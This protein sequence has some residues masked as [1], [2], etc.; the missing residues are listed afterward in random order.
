MESVDWNSCIICGDGSKAGMQCPLNNKHLTKD[1]DKIKSYENFL[2]SL[3]KLKDNGVPAEVKVSIDVSA[4]L[5]LEKRAS[6][7]KVCINRF[8]DEKVEKKIQ[9]F[10]RKSGD[11]SK[12]EE[13]DS[14]A[15]AKIPRVKTDFLL[16]ILCQ[17]DNIPHNH[18]HLVQ[19]LTFSQNVQTMAQA[20]GDSALLNRV[21]GSDLIAIDA[22]YHLACYRK[23]Q[24][25]YIK[26]QNSKKSSSESTKVFSEQAFQEVVQWIKDRYADGETN[27]LLKDLWDFWLERREEYGLDAMQNRTIF[28]ERLLAEFSGEMSEHNYEGRKVALCFNEGLKEV[29]NAVIKERNFSEDMKVLMKASKII[30]N[31][32][33]N[34]KTFSFLG[35][36]DS[37]C[38]R[39]SI[40]ASLYS[41]ISL[42]IN[43]IDKNVE[44]NHQATLSISQLVL[45]NL[46][47]SKNKDA[48]ISRHI[49]EAPLSVY[50]G[51]K[52]HVLTRSS[53]LIDI[54]YNLGL[55][56]H[57]KQVVKLEKQFASS[58]CHQ[59]TQQNAVIPPQL[60]KN[61]FTVGAFDNIDYNTSSYT[62][63]DS[64]HGTGISLHQ[65]PTPNSVAQDQLPMFNCSDVQMLP[66]SYTIVP[67]VALN[68]KK[69]EPT[70]MD[71]AS[72]VTR[73]LI[74]KWMREGIEWLN[75]AKGKALQD[76]SK[77]DH[78]GWASFFAEKANNHPPKSVQTMLPLFYEKAATA[79]M[80]KHS[81]SVILHATQI[82]NP[83]Q[84]AVIAAD[85][86]LFELAKF[87]QWASPETHGESK[88]IMKL[89]SLHLEKAFLTC[90]GDLL[91]G[92]GWENLLVEA[93]IIGSG[94]AKGLL[95]AGHITKTRL[96]HEVTALALCRLQ[97]D[98][99]QS[100]QLDVDEMDQRNSSNINFMYWN[101]IMNLE[102]LVLSFVRAHREG[103]F[104]MYI[105]TL[106]EL[107]GLFFVLDHQNYARWVPVH[108]R[109]MMM[110]PP[111]VKTEFENGNFVLSKTGKRF[112]S[113]AIDQSHEQLNKVIKGDG[114]IVGLIQNPDAMR[115][116]LVA[117]PD[118]AE[119]IQDFE[120]SM[121]Q[122]NDD[123]K[124]DHHEESLG[125][126]K[127]FQNM[128]QRLY[129]TI[130]DY[131]N[132]FAISTEDF[133]KLD[134]HSVFDEEVASNVRNLYKMGRS[135]YED[136]AKCVLK[137]GSKSIH[138]AIKKNSL[139]LLSSRTRAATTKDKRTRF[140]TKNTTLFAQLAASLHVREGNLEEFFKYELHSFPPSISDFGALYLPGN[141]SQILQV[142]IPADM[143]CPPRTLNAKIFDGAFLVHLL[144]TTNATTFDDYSNLFISYITDRLADT[145]RLDIVWDRYTSDSLKA[146][147]RKK[148]GEGARKHVTG[149]TKLPGKWADFLKNDL[150]KTD[151]FKFLTEKVSVHSFPHGK[152][153]YISHGRGT[154][155]TEGNS[156]NKCA[157]STMDRTNHEEADT[158]IT[159]HVR[160]AAIQGKRLIEV[161][162]GDSDVVIILMALYHNIKQG[163][164]LQDIWVFFG[165]GKTT[166]H[167]SI[168]TMTEAIGR[169]RCESLLMF[170]AITG[171]DTTSGF[172][173]CGKKKA[174]EALK[175][176]PQV[177]DLFCQCFRNPYDRV[178][179]NSSEFQAIEKF[180]VTMY[181]KK[182]DTSSVN[183]ARKIIF[184]QRSQNVE[185]IPPCQNSLYQH[186][187]RALYQASIWSSSL[188]TTMNLPGADGYG[189]SHLPDDPSGIKWSPVWMTQREA[190]EE[191]RKLFLTCTCNGVCTRC[192]C[193]SAGLNCTEMCS[194]SC[195]QKNT[196]QHKL[197]ESVPNMDRDIR[198]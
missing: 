35:K 115:R 136:Y 40:P 11:T 8:N 47:K 141:K 100:L 43:G 178:S 92:S 16:C 102:I 6:W 17:T 77:D 57:Y 32:M 164:N 104:E 185:H 186:Y 90:L 140:L 9:S 85:Q 144:P 41:L 83:G 60:F 165:V 44:K 52:T 56:I 4:D 160:H 107:V 131:G 152:A 20:L 70:K 180:I 155:T 38:Q 157:E 62:S 84:P 23:L 121:Q 108:I 194:C 113:I 10:K 46:K 122:S 191:C 119:A 97:N 33:F 156:A 66:E 75:H 170:H 168:A 124:L 58:L 19:T 25:R 51:L 80:V 183:L 82:L 1:E 120:V 175:M 132:P 149:A 145:D 148:R 133:V 137:E 139:K 196:Q 188:S 151:L 27:F 158:R 14:I 94:S 172:K 197:N 86:P 71:F 134:D 54:L 181:S 189:W 135:Q 39:E 127:K 88:I 3:K 110:L 143:Q 99:F 128:V 195:P 130:S 24:R 30:R 13:S 142:L 42:I 37:E 74:Q 169:K 21:L 190:M 81:M 193:A 5:L 163:T 153:V 67:E 69:I 117:G 73:D 28:K 93:D 109:D 154:L 103:N 53:T 162:T 26:K 173:S 161:R 182:I 7:H 79:A 111:S 147:T 63:V 166:Q 50:L 12:Q 48:A 187:L 45:F 126:Q 192:K 36:F 64:F 61:T 89:G 159:L 101:Q 114:G 78:F 112:S 146:A 98:A 31:D 72:M 198:A 105:E 91:A 106:K 118:L 34:H 177:E 18:T 95:S 116:W 174:W 125:F 150:N 59:F 87:V 68:L 179:I 15:V 76:I 138:D 171:A 55:S 96:M 167:L 65:S 123:E 184:F 2:K 22:R 49:R 29:I 129:E 176:V